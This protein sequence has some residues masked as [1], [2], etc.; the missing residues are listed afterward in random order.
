VFSKGITFI[1]DLKIA[2][3]ALRLICVDPLDRHEQ[4]GDTIYIVLFRKQSKL[5]EVHMEVW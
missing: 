2:K 4:Q 3:M 5:T 1:W